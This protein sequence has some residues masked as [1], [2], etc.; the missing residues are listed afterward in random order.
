LQ[1][2]Y[3]ILLIIFIANNS[4]LIR[5]YDTIVMMSRHNN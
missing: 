1:T 4:I 3:Q 2:W 5:H